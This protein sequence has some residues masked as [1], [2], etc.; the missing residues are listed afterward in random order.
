MWYMIYVYSIYSFPYFFNGHRLGHLVTESFRVDPQVRPSAWTTSSDQFWILG[1][2][3][4]GVAQRELHKGSW[5]IHT[6]KYGFKVV[7]SGYYWDINGYEWIYP[8]VNQHNYGKSPFIMGKL[9]TSMTVFNSY[10]ILPEG[11]R[12]FSTM[13]VMYSGRILRCELQ[14][15]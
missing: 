5:T 2:C 7:Y 11:I 8:L 15:A 3:T 14:G 10:V 1:P 6:P 4:T 12:S 9:T 13:G